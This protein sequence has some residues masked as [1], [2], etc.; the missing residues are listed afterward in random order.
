M[1]Q[2]REGSGV[3]AALKCGGKDA[4]SE[5]TTSVRLL[6]V[7]VGASLVVAAGWGALARRGR[8]GQ[9]TPAVLAA[10][11]ER[12]A[13]L[14]YPEAGA[15]PGSL[16]VEYDETKDRTRMMLTLTGVEAWADGARLSSV[17]LELASRY[18]GREREVGELSVQV[19]LTVVSSVAGVLATASPPGEWTVDAATFAAKA[20]EAGESGYRSVSKA[21]GWHERLA[22][23]VP[24]RDV[25]TMA[26]GRAVSG[27]FGKVR[28]R[29]SGA[30]VREVREFAARMKPVGAGTLR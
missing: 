3:E 12:A 26:T 19:E 1:V 22:F 11:Q 25:L 23:H 24:T 27:V 15:L 8:V 6:W 2:P 4:M 7:A 18:S 14:A 29:L 10:K 13:A 28:V 5:G 9:G 16:K 30:Q 17:K 21:D 20:V